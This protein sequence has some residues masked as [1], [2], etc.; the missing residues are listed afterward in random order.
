MP[1]E[2]TVK[3]FVKE[4]RGLPKSRAVGGDKRYYV[5]AKLSGD[6]PSVRSKAATGTNPAWNEL[7][8][9]EH[10]DLNEAVLTLTVKDDLPLL[11]GG[12]SRASRHGKATIPIKS[13]L[14]RKESKGKAAVG[15]EGKLKSKVATPETWYPLLNEDGTQYGEGAVLVELM[16][17]PKGGLAT[18]ESM[19]FDAKHGQAQAFI[20]KH[21]MMCRAYAKI[22]DIE[23]LKQVDD[24]LDSNVELHTVAGLKKTGREEAFNYLR[25]TCKRVQFYETQGIKADVDENGAITTE[26]Y[27]KLNYALIPMNISEKITWSKEGLAVLIHREKCGGVLDAGRAGLAFGLLHL[28]SIGSTLSASIFDAYK[29]IDTTEETEDIEKK[30]GIGRKIGSGAF[31]TVKIAMDNKDGGLR[32]IKIVNKPTDNNQDVLVELRKEMEIMTILGVHPHVMRMY[33]FSEDEAHVYFVLEFCSGGD[34]MDRLMS[35]KP[36]ELTEFEIQKTFKEIMLGLKHMHSTGVVHRDIKPE[37][38]LYKNKDADSPVVICDFGLS[39]TMRDEFSLRDA[40]GTPIY[41]APE[42]ILA[43]EKRKFH[44]KTGIPTTIT[45][46][47]GFPVD[48]WSSG[49]MLYVMASG[50]FP[51]YASKEEEMP[52]MFAEIVSGRYDLPNNLFGNKSKELKDL[53][54]G[55]LNPNPLKRLSIDD[56]LSHPFFKLSTK[57]QDVVKRDKNEAPPKSNNPKTVTVFESLPTHVARTQKPRVTQEEQERMLSKING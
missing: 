24:L 28:E 11:L 47:Y 23:K 48:I 27:I 9:L 1:H 25:Q 52:L 18:A 4:G 41:M 35:R 36:M 37:N 46:T 2:G 7:F 51:F 32:A 29:L 22:D 45:S 57:P 19:V 10:H 53:I 16:I 56:T 14:E 38:V 33:D 26:A 6:L 54:K 5:K 17:L 40:C 50:H 42:V 20:A 49:V 12:Q 34:M 39:A 21:E 3:V 44:E 8:T 31:G 30:Y 13:I 15:S 55:L 43:G